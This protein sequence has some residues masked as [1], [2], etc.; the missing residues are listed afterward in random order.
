MTSL[1]S[2]VIVPVLFSLLDTW[3]LI[4]TLFQEPSFMNLPSWLCPEKQEYFQFQYDTYEV[5]N[6]E[7]KYAAMAE[8]ADFYCNEA[9]KRLMKYS[10]GNSDPQ[11]SQNSAYWFEYEL[12]R[13]P[14]TEF[15]WEMVKVCGKDK[16]IP[17][18][19]DDSKGEFI[20]KPNTLLAQLTGTEIF[21][22]PGGHLGFLTVAQ[23]SAGKAEERTYHLSSS[24]CSINYNHEISFLNY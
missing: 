8:F 11:R 18:C 6:T 14:T 16:L 24:S 19:G 22:I 1:S 9:D 15:D 17:V 4:L 5:Y 12:R 23:P 3:L 21:E 2:L 10:Q 7:G 20:Y 13:Y